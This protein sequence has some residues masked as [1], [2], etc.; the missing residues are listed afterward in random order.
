MDDKVEREM[1]NILAERLYSSIG[2]KRKWVTLPL[3]LVK[4][5]IAALKKEG[6]VNNTANNSSDEI[7]L[8][9]ASFDKIINSY[10][11]KEN[12]EKW[13]Y[14]KMGCMTRLSHIL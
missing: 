8:F 9:S 14:V 10:H 4:E 7:A 3:A 5:T 13:K 2:E 11:S 12:I 6:G 1:Q